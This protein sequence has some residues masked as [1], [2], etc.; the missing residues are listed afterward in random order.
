VVYSLA[1]RPFTWAIIDLG[2]HLFP[3]AAET[4][5]PTGWPGIAL[6]AGGI[7]VG[8]LLGTCA[9]RHA[10]CRTL[11]GMPALLDPAVTCAVV[12]ITVLAGYCGQLLFL[13]GQQERLPGTQDGGGAPPGQRARLKLLETQLEP[14]MLFNTLANLRVL[15]GT[16]PPAPRTCWTT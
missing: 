2:R 12:L 6:V 11:A 7:V 15:I 13:C 4:G 9:G 16:D 5:W 3:S 10:C 8:Y 14:H 1:D